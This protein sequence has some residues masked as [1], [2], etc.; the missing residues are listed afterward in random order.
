MNYYFIFDFED[1]L[2]GASKGNSEK[3]ALEDAVNRNLI[4]WKPFEIDYYKA[5]E[6]TKKELKQL[7]LKQ[8][9][10]LIQFKSIF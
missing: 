4:P 9:N 7:I 2:I 8:E 3:E 5:K 10:Q 6:V 1:N